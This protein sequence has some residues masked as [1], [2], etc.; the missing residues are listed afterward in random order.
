MRGTGVYMIGESHTEGR[1]R[2]NRGWLGSKRGSRGQSA[3]E[4][5]L[6]SIAFLLV[7]LLG[8]Q[9]AIIGQAALAL[10]QGASAIARY[11]AIAEP[12]GGIGL[13]YSGTPNA[14]MQA[15]LSP[16]ILTNGGGDLTVTINS[17]KGG[18]A[19]TAATNPVTPTVDRAVVTLSYS[20]S[21]KVVLP[22]SFLGSL[23]V[24][25]ALSAS[26]SQPYE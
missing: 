20:T 11:A 12:Q 14:A 4:F 25:A 10:S 19:S 23:T 3:V 16:T 6:I 7:I 15:L 26:D 13:T 5:A 24:P 18:T 21:S 9:W 22:S 8:V 17:Y 2:V 1:A